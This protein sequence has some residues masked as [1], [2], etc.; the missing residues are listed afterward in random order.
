[1]KKLREIVEKNETV[2]YKTTEPEAPKPKNWVQSFFGSMY[3]T[4]RQVSSVTPLPQFD[5]SQSAMPDMDAMVKQ[6][7]P[8]APKNTMPSQTGVAK[9]NIPVGSLPKQKEPEPK[10]TA[11]PV[12]SQTGF[13]AAE[14]TKAPIPKAKPEQSEIVI[15]PKQ[16]IWDIAGGDPKRVKEILKLNPGLNP[17]KMK[18]GYK[19]KLK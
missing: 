3:G 9:A 7:T 17:N 19:L 10:V 12:V 5:K 4:N 11:R 13:P 18:V 16:K 6:E 8:S 2:L 1:M 14:K 15:Q